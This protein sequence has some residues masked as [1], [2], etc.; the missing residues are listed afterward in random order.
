VNGT[1]SCR[2]DSFGLWSHEVSMMGW[3]TTVLVCLAATQAT[4]LQWHHTTPLDSKPRTPQLAAKFPESHRHSYLSCTAARELRVMVAGEGI[5]VF[6]RW[7]ARGCPST[8]QQL[9]YQVPVL[10][11]C[12]CCSSACGAHEQ[13]CRSCGKQTRSDVSMYAAGHFHTQ[14]ASSYVVSS[15]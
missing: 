5:W 6:A 15:A 8:R 11:C 7:Q 4:M 1:S 14:H 12:S 3:G 10:L 2:H 13:R 9:F